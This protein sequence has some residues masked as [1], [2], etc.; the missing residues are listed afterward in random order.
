MPVIARIAD[1][2]DD[3]TAW[4]RDFHAHPELGFEEVR[5]AGLVAERLAA[6]GIEVHAGVGRTGV[7]GVLRGRGG[8]RTIGLRADMEVGRRDPSF[9]YGRAFVSAWCGLSEWE[10]RT[11]IERLVELGVIEKVGAAGP[12]KTPLYRVGTDRRPS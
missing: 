6:W 10:A 12:F 2:A 11:A 3:L 4:R 9:P 7:V 8:G 1:F 5:T